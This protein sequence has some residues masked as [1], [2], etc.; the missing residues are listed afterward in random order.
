MIAQ[1]E[2]F[3]GKDHSDKFWKLAQNAQ[4]S[5]KLIYSALS[6]CDLIVNQFSMLQLGVDSFFDDVQQNYERLEKTISSPNPTSVQEVD[7]ADAIA[8]RS[9]AP[10]EPTSTAV[11]EAASSSLT[12]SSQSQQSSEQITWS[13]FRAELDAIFHNLLEVKLNCIQ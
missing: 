3:I 13:S 2:H 7:F 11:L 12:I 4:S 8:A 10:S 1:M 9:I 5:A 6:L